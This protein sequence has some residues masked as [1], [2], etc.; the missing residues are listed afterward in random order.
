MTIAEF[1]WT[2]GVPTDCGLC[3]WSVPFDNA[4]AAERG[5]AQHR[6]RLHPDLVPA[7]EICDQ[8]WDEHGSERDAIIWAIEH[9]AAEHGGRV[10]PNEVRTLIPPHVTPQLIGSVYNVLGRRG[11]LRRTE[12]RVP[13]RDTRGRNT[14]KDLP[15]YLLIA[16]AVTA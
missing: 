7:D 13:N 8:L 9:V 16:E 6:E 1:Q 3:P 10:D 11:R 14:N 4:A 5:L 2:K 12:E 15:I